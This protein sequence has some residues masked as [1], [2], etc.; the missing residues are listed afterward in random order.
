MNR[1]EFRLEVRVDVI[2]IGSGYIWPGARR[3]V[4]RVGIRDGSYYK[5]E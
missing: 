5:K 1:R 2:S 4:N 3:T